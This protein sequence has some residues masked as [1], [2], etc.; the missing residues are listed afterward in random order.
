MKVK[1]VSLILLLM[2]VAYPLRGYYQ[3]IPSVKYTYGN[4]LYDFSSLMDDEEGY[5]ELILKFW[6]KQKKGN[7][8]FRGDMYG[9]ILLN[10]N[11]K[12]YRNTSPFQHMWR[13]TPPELSRGNSLDIKLAVGELSFGLKKSRLEAYVGLIPFT[14]SLLS[15]SDSLFGT[16]L[17]YGIV[18]SEGKKLLMGFAWGGYLARSADERRWILEATPAPTGWGF[19]FPDHSALFLWVG[20]EGENFKSRF[21][22]SENSDSL[23]NSG[24]TGVF[25][26]K[27]TAIDVEYV[28]S[29]SSL[30]RGDAFL[31]SGKVGNDKNFIKAGY[32]DV[33]GY[34]Y[35]IVGNEKQSA[36]QCMEAFPPAGKILLPYLRNLPP[37]ILTFVD[38]ELN[39]GSFG[40]RLSAFRYAASGY[41]KPFSS[42]L[43]TEVDSGLSF[44]GGFYFLKLDYS[45]LFSGEG[46][47]EIVSD[48]L[49]EN[50]L[51]SNF[52]VR[53]TTLLSVEGGVRF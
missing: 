39:K 18:K 50:R 6:W 47:K 49:T 5:G 33:S 41:S 28:V 20:A 45:L 43:G 48:Y 4:N 40:V 23:K 52:S 34:D 53:R 3:F 15:F 36:F 37:L 25:F 21:F 9:S 17:K 27:N 35:T 26:K 44:D 14:Q 11:G 30:S 10:G 13:Y 24:F 32:V 51:Q 19:P 31:I 38:G 7:F 46:L 2:I 16:L 12:L 1:G 29:R 42:Y 8:L 22:F